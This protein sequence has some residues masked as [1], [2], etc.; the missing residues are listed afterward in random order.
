MKW[1]LTDGARSYNIL[2]IYIYI[3]IQ[4]EREDNIT[5]RSQGKNQFKKCLKRTLSVDFNKTH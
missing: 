5:V 1:E 4:N 2:H 3:Y